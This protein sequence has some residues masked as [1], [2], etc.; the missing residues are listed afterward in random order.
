V[1]FDDSSGI[2]VSVIEVKLFTAYG[3]CDNKISARF[4][5]ELFDIG[6]LIKIKIIPETGFNT[7]SRQP[8]IG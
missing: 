5:I 2:S 7:A 8:A 1:K 3:T 6:D 4:T